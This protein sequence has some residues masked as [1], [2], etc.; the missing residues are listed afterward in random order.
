MDTSL[1]SVVWNQI[2]DPSE[3]LCTLC[4]DARMEKA[5]VNCNEA[6]F[7]FVGKRLLSKLYTESHGDVARLERLVE[8]YAEALRAAEGIHDRYCDRVG[9]ADGWAREVHAMIK[10]ALNPEQQDTTEN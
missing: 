1:P 9:A 6:E 4:I 7:Y 2:A 10:E 8:R 3:M 5:G